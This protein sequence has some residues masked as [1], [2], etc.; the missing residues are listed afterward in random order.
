M[1]RPAGQAPGVIVITYYIIHIYVYVYL[2]LHLAPVRA[3]PGQLQCRGL[4]VVQAAAGRPVGCAPAGCVKCAHGVRQPA[5]WQVLIYIY[6]YILFN[7]FNIY[8]YYI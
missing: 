6:I 1:D 7:G 8:T 5:W 3:A 4:M 2:C